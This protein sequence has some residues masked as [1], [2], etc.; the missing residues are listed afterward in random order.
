MEN[1]VHYT[2]WKILTDGRAGFICLSHNG[3]SEE[4][5]LVTYAPLT[6]ERCHQA[7]YA[8]FSWNQACANCDSLVQRKNMMRTASLAFISLACLSL[9]EAK[10]EFL[11]SNPITFFDDCRY[12]NPVKEL[13]VDGGA[14][15]HQLKTAPKG[16]NVPKGCKAILYS[17]SSFE[18]AANHP[19]HAI[20]IVGPKKVCVAPYMK[21]VS[22]EISHDIDVT[23][24]FKEIEEERRETRVELKKQ[25]AEFVN[26]LSSIRQEIEEGRL[27]GPQGKPGKDGVGITGAQGLPGKEGVGIPGKP[28]RPGKDGVEG[29]RGEP[30]PQGRPG[31]DGKDGRAGKN[32]VGATG[33]AGPKGERGEEGARGLRGPPGLRGN[34]GEQGAPGLGLQLKI[35]KIGNSYKK[36]DYVFVK[37]A[38]HDIMYVAEQ[39]FVAKKVPADEPANWVPFK[40]PAGPKGERG[41][42]GATGNDGEKGVRGDK[43]APGKPGSDGKPGEDGKSGKDGRDG[44]GLTLKEFKM[45]AAYNKG[46]YVFAKASKSDHHSMFIAQKSFTAKQFP[47]SDFNNWVEFEAPK[48]EKGEKGPTGPRGPPGLSQQKCLISGRDGKTYFDKA[49]YKN[50]CEKQCAGL[51]KTRKYR[52]CKFGNSIIRHR[53]AK[54]RCYIDGKSGHVKYNQLTY[55]DECTRACNGTPGLYRQCKYGHRIIRHRPARQRCYVDGKSGRVK[56]NQMTYPDEC[57]V[58]CFQR[59]TGHYRQ[60]RYGHRIIR[61]RH[62][63]L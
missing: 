1:E 26:N 31:K 9:G 44:I 17:K 61:H 62:Q 50:E 53:P 10:E 52:Q 63:R 8:A 42:N 16:V 57:N 59:T 46:D 12:H 56:Y 47:A 15:L 23:K 37:S 34:Q 58:A 14:T 49:T 5:V 43:G 6:L 38:T 33:E 22:V 40:A 39:N 18:Y 30:G 4:D 45:G 29:P 25:R 27:R 24:L 20:S 55:P 7:V 28:G 3:S 19:S 32:G 11:C 21:A 36:G 2:P 13:H 51:D 54:Q 35:F 48:G 41:D 60:C